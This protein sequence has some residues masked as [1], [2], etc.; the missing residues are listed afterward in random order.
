MEC[1]FM[2]GKTKFPQNISNVFTYGFQCLLAFGTKLSYAKI[3]SRK[4]LASRT[5]FTTFKTVTGFPSLKCNL[6]YLFL[7][8]I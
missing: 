6:I 3:F 7:I 2:F 1:L 8:V 5:K 4:Q